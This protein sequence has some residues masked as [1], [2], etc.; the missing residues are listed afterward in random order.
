[1]ARMNNNRC[2]NAIIDGEFVDMLT[3]E[4]IMHLNKNIV[5][6]ITKEYYPINSYGQM[7]ENKKI[8][9]L[10]TSDTPTSYSEYIYNYNNLPSI[11]GVIPIN[12]DDIEICKHYNFVDNNNNNNNKHKRKMFEA[13]I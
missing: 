5:S 2:Y 13:D 12:D 9:T 11:Y 4:D 7:S 3:K 6:F 1:M 8:I 10:Y